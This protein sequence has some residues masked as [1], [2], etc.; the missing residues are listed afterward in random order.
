MRKKSKTSPPPPPAHTRSQ[1]GAIRDISD[2]LVVSEAWD[3]WVTGRAHR[4]SWPPGLLDEVTTR[5]RSEWVDARKTA[6]ASLNR[7]ESAIEL[8]DDEVAELRDDA[9]RHGRDLTDAHAEGVKAG[10][11]ESARRIAV[12]AENLPED[13]DWTPSELSALIDRIIARINE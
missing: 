9:Q 7:F 1:L 8:I 5:M 6:R 10:K 2:L 11:A 12:L 13:S 3:E 4:A